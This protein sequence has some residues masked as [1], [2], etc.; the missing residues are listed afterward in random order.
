MFFTKE[1]FEFLKDLT[2]N[3]NREWFAE[4]KSRYVEDV[5]MPGLALI[6]AVAKPLRNVA[7]FIVA[8]PAKSGGSMTR[9]YRDTRFSPGTSCPNSTS[10]EPQQAGQT[11]SILTATSR[12]VLNG[13]I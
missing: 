6:A 7:P 9:V 1:T 11:Y 10:P 5:Q 4:N 8:N 13:R 2:A 12:L 3:K